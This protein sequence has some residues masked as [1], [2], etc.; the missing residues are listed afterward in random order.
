MSGREIKISVYHR[1]VK[2]ELTTCRQITQS[3]TILQIVVD[4]YYVPDTEQDQQRIKDEKEETCPQRV[5]SPIRRMRAECK[6][7]K[8]KG[9]KATRQLEREK[10]IWYI[11]AYIWN[12]ERWY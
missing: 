8:Y 10:Q 11:S 6:S 9:G 4:T 5:C 1:E 3:N 7:Q 2:T 12:L